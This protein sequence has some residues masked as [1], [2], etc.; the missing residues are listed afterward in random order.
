MHGSSP[1]RPF[2]LAPGDLDRLETLRHKWSLQRLST[3][4]ADR[5]RAEEGVALAYAAAGLAPPARIE[6]AKGPGE[7]ARSWA[8][9]RYTELPGANVGEQVVHRVREQAVHVIWKTFTGGLRLMQGHSLRSPEDRAADEVARVFVASAEKVGAS[10]WLRMKHGLTNL[11]QLRRRAGVGHTFGRASISSIELGWLRCAWFMHQC[12]GEDSELA[13]L[14]GLHL[15]AESCGWLLP[16][17]KVCWVCERPTALKYDVRGRLHD[18]KGPAL[19]YADGSLHYAWK[20]VEVP[21]DLI[22]YAD[23]ITA[24]AVDRERDPI[25]RRTMIEIMTPARFI[26]M[27]GALRAGQD[28]TGILWRK[29]WWTG[30]SWAAVE[31]VNGTAERDGTR[32]RYYLQVPPEMPTPRAA[33]A[34]TYG[35]SESQY[36]RL[37]QRT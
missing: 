32:T 6:W 31:V 3:E 25:L 28:E 1:I 27:G 33:V 11:L 26:A 7:M 9:A 34:W 18:A 17:E 21:R 37:T 29:S 12:T 16:H 20:G 15:I 23:E 30:D 14:R 10:P 19:A 5:A 36:R 4:P 8:N 2:T 24:M 13:N 22:E 35:L